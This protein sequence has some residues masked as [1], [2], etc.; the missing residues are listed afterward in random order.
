[1]DT[2]Q[3]SST[4][5]QR[6]PCNR[7]HERVPGT[8]LIGGR[9]RLGVS[10]CTCRRRPPPDNSVQLTTSQ[11]SELDNRLA[12]ARRLTQERIAEERRLAIAERERQERERRKRRRNREEEANN[13]DTNDDDRQACLLREQNERALQA[14]AQREA[15]ERA[16][17][18]RAALAQQEARANLGSSHQAANLQALLSGMVSQE[19][20]Q[21]QANLVTAM[22]DSLEDLQSQQQAFQDQSREANAS[23]MAAIERL[24]VSVSSGPRPSPETNSGTSAVTLFAWIDQATVDLVAKDQLRIEHLIKLRNPDNTVTKEPPQERQTVQTGQG[25]QLILTTDELPAVRAS[26]FVRAIPNVLA[27]A[28][29]WTTY[30]AIRTFYIEDKALLASYNAFLLRVIELSEDYDWNE[31]VAR[32][33]MAVCRKRF[34]VAKAVEW[35]HDDQTAFNSY[36]SPNLKTRPGRAFQSTP[37]GP[38]SAAPP[39][40]LSRPAAVCLRYNVEDSCVNCKRA[41]LCSGCRG[42]HPRSRCPSNQQDAAPPFPA[43]GGYKGKGTGANV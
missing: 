30:I 17:Q 10:C 35:V 16:Q 5:S 43:K 31:G 28:G 6:Y 38:P 27:F 21:V 14:L 34:G 26:A 39:G 2:A 18:E 42:N 37:W 24:A 25:G 15:E 12:T 7:C 22:R 1:M 33:I 32:Y 4:D 13:N 9:G 41:H 29:L 36:L 40:S 23:M 19:T 11:R 8:W 20:F 3:P